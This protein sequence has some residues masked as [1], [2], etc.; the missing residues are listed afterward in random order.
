[1][2]AK[3]KKIGQQSIQ[4]PTLP[5]ATCPPGSTLAPNGQCS[6]PTNIGLFRPQSV[7]RGVPKKGPF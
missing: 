7:Y 3:L 4:T 1:M 6:W 5:R 2:S